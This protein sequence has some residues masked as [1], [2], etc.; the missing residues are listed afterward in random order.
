MPDNYWGVGYQ[1]GRYTEVSDSTTNY[2]RNWGQFKFKIV[3]RIVPN[4]YLGLNYDRNRT[5]AT[6]LSER[7][8]NDT[9]FLKHGAE[10]RNSG[11][12]MVIRYDSRDFPE[13]AYKGILFE[14]AGTGYAKHTT[15]NNIFR[16]FELDYRQYQQ[17]VRKGSTLAWQFKTRN[18]SGDVPWTELSMVGTPFDLRGYPWGQYRDYTM[19]FA[20]AEYRYMLPRKKPNS[21]GDLYGP[22]GF[23]LW[24]GVGTV[25]ENYGKIKYWIPNAGVGLRFE[26]QDRMNIRIDYGFGIESS[27]FY[28]SFTEAF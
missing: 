6:E 28:I 5:D 17:I 3:Y 22:F 21:R 23:A 1:A 27:A 9:D 19:L 13:N 16:V 10:I 26:L 20:L 24:S 11:F 4:F 18:A 12:G 8:A 7:M 25:A 15:S 14:V 2:H